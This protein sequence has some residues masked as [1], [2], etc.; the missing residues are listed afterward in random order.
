MHETFGDP[1]PP[2]AFAAKRIDAL[3]EGGGEDAAGTPAG[4]QGGQ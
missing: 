3:R 1:V 4:E 2:H